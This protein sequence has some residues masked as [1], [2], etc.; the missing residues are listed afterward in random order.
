MPTTAHKLPGMHPA[1]HRGHLTF[2]RASPQYSDDV[3][4]QRYLM[5]DMIFKNI[6]NVI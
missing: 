3:M 4:L 6:D 2:N 1:L 5:E